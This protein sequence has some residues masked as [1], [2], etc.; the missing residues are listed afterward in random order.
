MEDTSELAWKEKERL[1]V[2][3]AGESDRI[4][5][6]EPI[7]GSKGQKT[8]EVGSGREEGENQAISNKSKTGS[9]AKRIDACSS[10]PVRHK[11]DNKDRKSDR[12]VKGEY[13]PIRRSSAQL[14]IVYPSGICYQDK[15]SVPCYPHYWK[16]VETIYGGCLFRC[17]ICHKHK[18]LPITLLDA[19]ELGDLL[20]KKGN[21]GYC[22]YLDKKR[23]RPAKILMAKLQE[24]ER[25]RESTDDTYI[26]A[27]AAL[28]ILKQKEYDKV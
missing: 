4:S 26:L 24:L 19:Y 6:Q 10:R 21:D 15:N 22:E 27:K 3:L 16:E 1:S 25:L 11:R 13:T 17:D 5:K 9:K 14:G 28:H 2:L 12:G 8:L 7:L 20:K 23:N 18:W